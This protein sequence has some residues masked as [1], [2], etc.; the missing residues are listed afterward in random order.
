MLPRADDPALT[1]VRGLAALWVFVYHAWRS[2]DPHRLVVHAGGAALD[3]TPLASAGWAGVDV[4]YVLSGFLLW[5]MFDDYAAG[6]SERVALLRY[7]RRRAL[8]ILPPYYAQ[9]ALL[10]VLGLVTTWVERPT[11]TAIA[12]IVTLT[13]N[14]SYEHFQAINNVWWTL[15]VEAQFYVTLPL[16]AFTVRRA[17]WAPVLIL[18]FATMLAWRIVAF[19][20]FSDAPVYER[21]WILEQF[22]GHIDQFLC[23]MFASHLAFARDGA[24]AELR[25]R[26]MHHARWRTLAVAIGPAALVA[27][28]YLL[29]VGDFYL[30]YWEGHPWLYAWH[31]VA[32]IAVAVSLYAL[33]VRPAATASAAGSFVGRALVAFGITSY[34]FYLWH[35]LLLRWVSVW[36]KATFG[37]ATTTAFAVNVALGFPLALGVATLWYLAFERP[38]LRARS[39]H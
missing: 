13:Q 7:A 30:S 15:S 26:A 34:S 37:A 24:G 27:L 21:F 25:A 39:R 4:F 35:E 32:G 11:W 12:F 22:P 20:L 2:A 1:A 6:R 14:W 9:V 36:V 31:A 8:R 18:G 28:A 19:H 3:F 16:L 38:F 23:G 29:H 10:A 33:A 17:G 5:R